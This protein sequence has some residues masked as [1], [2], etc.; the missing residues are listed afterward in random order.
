MSGFQQKIKRHTKRQKTP[1][2]ETE[3][4]SEPVL[5]TLGRL[6]LSDHEFKT[7]MINMI[8]V[9]MKKVKLKKQVSN[10]NRDEY[11]RN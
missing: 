4:E 11:S 8:S 9:L 7:T 6:E 5:D 3:Q 2:E 1:F 10:V